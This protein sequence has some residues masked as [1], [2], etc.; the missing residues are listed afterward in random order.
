MF[1]L[2]KRR[3]KIKSDTIL[4]LCGYPTKIDKRNVIVYQQNLIDFLIKNK[5]M[6]EF[7]K[8]V[9][10]IVLFLEENDDNDSDNAVYLLEELSSLYNVYMNKYEKYLSAREKRDI[11]KNINI[12]SNELKK[13]SR[14]KKVSAAK[15]GGRTR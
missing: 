13:T 10:Q 8:L 14:V 9:T 11:I 7:N 4:E 1:T 6:P 2:V 5:F 12:L 3:G 15:T